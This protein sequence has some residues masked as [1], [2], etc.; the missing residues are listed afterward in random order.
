M[1][2]GRGR[3]SERTSDGGGGTEDTLSLEGR[4]TTQMGLLE[5]K[6]AGGTVFLTYDRPNF[7]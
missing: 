7:P 2:K 6:N 1:K 5:F 4:G 3:E